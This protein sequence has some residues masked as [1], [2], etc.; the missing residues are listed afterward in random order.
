MEQ[1]NRFGPEPIWLTQVMYRGMEQA[2][3]KALRAT[4][5]FTAMY[6]TVENTGSQTTQTPNAP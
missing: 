5:L 1:H 4:F 2:A 6:T 3:Q